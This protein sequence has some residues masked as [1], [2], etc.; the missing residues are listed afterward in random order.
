ME[1]SID[2]LAQLHEFLKT[3]NDKITIA[4]N[5][6][7]VDDTIKY[8]SKTRKLLNFML[9]SL[10]NATLEMSHIKEFIESCTY[11]PTDLISI[12]QKKMLLSCQ[13]LCQQIHT[14]TAKVFEWNIK[15][16]ENLNEEG[17]LIPDELESCSS[18]TTAD[19]P[20]F[21][22]EDLLASY[23]EIRSILKEIH[24][25]LLLLDYEQ[26]INKAGL[27]LEVKEGNNLFIETPREMDTLI[28]Y[29][30]FEYRKNG[31]NI[32]ESYFE[33][34]HSLYGPQNLEIL[35]ALK[36]AR[37]SLLEILEPMYECGLKVRDRLINQELFLIDRG[38]YRT[39]CKTNNKYYLLTH[40]LNMPL[41]SL[42]TGAAT[43][44]LQKS[45][46]GSGIWNIFEKMLQLKNTPTVHNKIELQHRC[47]TSIYKMVI[48]EGGVNQVFMS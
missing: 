37:F 29:G 33:K 7:Q 26:M 13:K 47:I 30:L 11:I 1:L 44:I 5:I 25:E 15:L 39:I 27:A 14:K 20:K 16:R 2:N 36:N 21:S 32:V 34:N 28:D 17:C 10:S 31:K 24:T 19:D 42:T 38:L 43:P 41:F 9:D 40:Y 45:A 48:H 22:K 23:D 3:I 35:T 18:V 8:T 46:I 6:L 12:T 4:E